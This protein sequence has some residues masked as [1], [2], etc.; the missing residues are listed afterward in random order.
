MGLFLVIHSNNII[1]SPV[2]ILSAKN[3]GKPTTL[4]ELTVL[5]QT[6]I[7]GGEGAFCPLPKNPTPDLGLWPRFSA[8]QASFGSRPNSL[9]SPN[10]WVWIKHCTG[11]L[12]TTLYSEKFPSTPTGMKTPHTYPIVVSGLN[13]SAECLPL[14]N[15]ANRKIRLIFG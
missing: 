12:I 1:M 14:Y 6:P 10:S 15:P 13:V 4:R 2:T 8:L 9:H 3:S 5:P 11:A 7:A